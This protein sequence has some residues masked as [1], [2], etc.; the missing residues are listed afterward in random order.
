MSYIKKIFKMSFEFDDIFRKI[1]GIENESTPSSRI[2]IKHTG[3]KYWFSTRVYYRNNKEVVCIELYITDYSADKKFVLF[4]VFSLKRN[5]IKAMFIKSPS[6]KEY[7]SFYIFDE[8]D[9]PEFNSFV[10]RK[11]LKS[12]GF[13][14]SL[15]KDIY[16]K[17][18]ESIVEYI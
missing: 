8:V 16:N 13:S 2:M 18:F 1:F 5:T 12:L 6:S 4:V 14:Y 7:H 17:M 10:L 9:Y 3:E 15:F 11:I